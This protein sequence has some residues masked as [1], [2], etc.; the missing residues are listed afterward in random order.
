MYS[1]ETILVITYPVRLFIMFIQIWLLVLSNE[2]L[3]Y[4]HLL[5]HLF[6]S[7]NQSINGIA[8]IQNDKQQS[9]KI[10]LFYILILNT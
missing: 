1:M 3:Y 9:F 7:N 5:I 4:I 6:A 8:Y 10:I 2:L